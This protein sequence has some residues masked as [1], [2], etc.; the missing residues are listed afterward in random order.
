MVVERWAKNPPER[1][2]TGLVLPGWIAK[3]DIHDDVSTIG[4]SCLNRG[5]SKFAC[6]RN[7]C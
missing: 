1:D 6:W 4:A 5:S 7:K 3:R 2:Y